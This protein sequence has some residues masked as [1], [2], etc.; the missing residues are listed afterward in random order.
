[1]APALQGSANTLGLKACQ[2]KETRNKK[3]IKN[4]DKMKELSKHVSN[5]L[6]KIKWPLKSNV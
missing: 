6:G 1:M 5:K 4:W 2:S 3:N